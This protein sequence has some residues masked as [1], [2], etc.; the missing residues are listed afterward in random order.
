[1]NE[2]AALNS[3]KEE[4]IATCREILRFKTVKGEKAEN[5]P[6]G[7]EIA[8]CLDYTLNKC[9][10]ANLSIY[11]CDYYAGHAD[12]GTQ[13]EVFGILG[14]LDVV[15]ADED[16]WIAPPF[17]AS[18]IG[19]KLYGRGTMDDKLPMIACLYAIK[20][21]QLA[22]IEPKKT[23]RLIFGCDEE[24]GME[25]VKYY[26]TKMPKP[27]FG[28]SPDGNFPIINREKGIIGFKLNLGKVH[29][30]IYDITCGS[31]RNVVPNLCQ[32]K[33]SLDADLSSLPKEITVTKEKECYV[34]SATGKS[35]HGSLPQE[36]DN[37]SW[38]IFKALHTLYP[39]CKAIAYAAEKLCDYTGTKLG[40]NLSDEPSGALTI[41]VGVVRVEKGELIVT[42]DNRH[43][44]TFTNK[45]VVSL[46]AR[47]CKDCGLEVLSES[48]PL[49][50]P[51]ESELVQTLL[52][53]YKD[54]TGYDA[55]AMSIGGG[56][57]SRCIDNCVAFGPEF[58]GDGST[59]HMPNEYIELDRL[60]LLAKIYMEA[61]KRL[62]C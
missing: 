60:M 62:V 31:R 45:Q 28:I 17:E 11:N 42:I 43:P 35:C 26:L 40:V 12:W 58:P 52:S 38:K 57:Y 15:P 4:F 25:C 55:Y 27:D 61:I 49:F 19:D 48:E 2:I 21:L 14:H 32:A 59:I 3:L 23:V 34:L 29:K 47:C 54:T 41:N 16:S 36:G 39:E 10:E 33:V 44:V 1:M 53:V 9:K 50:V 18:I 56:T 13:G 46:F 20:A 51:E 5:A 6:F 30:D 7:M 24:S 8:K 22:G 37:A